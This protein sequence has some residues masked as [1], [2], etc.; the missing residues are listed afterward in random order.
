MPVLSGTVNEINDNDGMI[1]EIVNRFAVLASRFESKGF[2]GLLPA[3]G[4]FYVD[5]PVLR[6]RARFKAFMDCA[7]PLFSDEMREKIDNC[8]RDFEEP[9][10]QSQL[11]KFKVNLYDDIMAEE[12]EEEEPVVEPGEVFPWEVTNWGHSLGWLLRTLPENGISPGH[13]AFVL[14][15][16]KDVTEYILIVRWLK[17][18]NDAIKDMAGELMKYA[19]EWSDDNVCSDLSH[20]RC[21]PKDFE[22]GRKFMRKVRELIEQLKD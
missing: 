18:E 17:V 5:Q 7:L 9:V 12:E 19:E 11:D 4:K 1:Q 22:R 14:A 16:F 13:E 8:I 21:G 15:D 10:K 6:H 20:V 3:K 2:V